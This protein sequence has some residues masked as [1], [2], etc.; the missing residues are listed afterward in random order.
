MSSKGALTTGAYTQRTIEMGMRHP[1]LVVGFIASK[2]IELIPATEDFKTMTGS[3]PPP[4]T[5][6]IIFTPGIRVASSG[7]LHGQQYSSPESCVS[8]GTDVI[9]VGR[10]IISAENPREAAK[11]YQLLGWTAYLSRLTTA[12]PILE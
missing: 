9:I 8:Q 3:S 5:D 4:S 6:F 11:Q 10:G 1:N 7:D 2:A 12:T